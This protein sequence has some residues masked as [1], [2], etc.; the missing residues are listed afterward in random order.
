MFSSLKSKRSQHNQGFCNTDLC[1]HLGTGS[2]RSPSGI[3]CC[4][5]AAVKSSTASV[6]WFWRPVLFPLLFLHRCIC[7]LVALRVL[8]PSLVFGDL[9]DNL[10]PTFMHLGFCS[11]FM[12]VLEDQK[13]CYQCLLYLNISHPNL[14][15]LINIS[16]FSVSYISFF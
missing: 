1:T 5:Q 15:I 4:A 7:G 3:R 12:V 14:G 13:T 6:T 9:W 16:F 8:S 11:V 10:S 2:H